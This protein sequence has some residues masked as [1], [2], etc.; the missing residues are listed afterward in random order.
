MQFTSIAYK[1]ITMVKRRELTSEEKACAERANAL[2]RKK[3]RLEKISQAAAAAELG[4]TTSAF[5]QYIN[6]KIPMNTDATAKIAAYL[7][8]SPREI[9]P[10]WLV[11]KTSGGAGLESELMELLDASKPSDWVAGFKQAAGRV[12]PKDAMKIARF[13]LDRAESGL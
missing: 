8:V 7:A 10:K 9:N 12:S 13:F 5:N 3:S 6:G 11:E 4:F 1:V 2:W